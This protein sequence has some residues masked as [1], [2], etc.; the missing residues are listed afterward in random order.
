MNPKDG[1]SSSNPT[2]PQSSANFSRKPLPAANKSSSSKTRFAPILLKPSTKPPPTDEVIDVDEIGETIVNNDMHARKRHRIEPAV[3]RR[4]PPSNEALVEGLQAHFGYA[5]FRGFQQEVVRDVVC[6]KDVLV[7]MPTGGG[8][9]ICYQLPALLLPGIAIIISPL[10]ALMQDQ[11]DALRRRGIGAACFHSALPAPVRAQLITVLSSLT[12][13]TSSS[14]APSSSSSLSALP[15]IPHPLKL[16]YTTPETLTS[17]RFFK[18]LN[19]LRLSGQLSM[20][21]V[22]EA[23]C[24]SEWGHEFR[25]AYRKIGQIRDMLQGVPLVA[26]TATANATVK[27]DIVSQ[28]KLQNPGMYMA[29]FDRPEIYYSVAYKDHV[30]SLYAHLIKFLKQCG[31]RKRADNEPSASGIIYCQK[32]TSCDELASQLH[33]DGFQARAYHAGLSDSDRQQILDGFIKD[34]VSIVVATIAFGMGIDKHNVRFVVH[35]E[36][37]AN[38]ESFYQ[39]SGRAG[40]DKKCS[41]SLVYYSKDDSGVREF[42]ARQTIAKE[43]E[44]PM[45]KHAN[46]TCPLES[47]QKLKAVFEAFTCRRAAILEFFGEKRLSSAT[48]T[49]P[50]PK[51]TPPTSTPPSST[52]PAMSHIA[53]LRA[54]LCKATAVSSSPPPAIGGLGYGCCD[55]CNDTANAR[56]HFNAFA[57]PTRSFTGNRAKARADTKGLEMK[58]DWDED[59]FDEHD[60]HSDEDTSHAPQTHLTGF[61]SARDVLTQ[62]EATGPETVLRFVVDAKN[63]MQVQSVGAMHRSST[64]LSMIRGLPAVIDKVATNEIEK[65]RDSLPSSDDAMEKSC[66]VLRAVAA[67]EHTMCFLVSSHITQYN[68]TAQHVITNILSKLGGVAE[69]TKLAGIRVGGNG[70]GGNSAN[71]RGRQL[72][73]TEAVGSKKRTASPPKDIFELF[74]I[75]T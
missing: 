58:W 45:Q 13:P 2:R 35:M 15:P 55:V 28:L 34:T 1:L 43:L 5:S 53:S 40:R 16:L 19:D 18:I 59:G 10:I 49:P 62:A 17:D 74:G 72:T 60:R 14:D 33:T 67:L 73:L 44:A 66:V 46:R 75:K 6:G 37:P 68:N 20:V 9:S 48:S 24:I 26:T 21:A 30:P 12:L 8:K 25:P 27:K 63:V 57:H 31:A 32:R 71:G 65:V 29:S 41:Y 56:A 11:V 52:P 7:I 51:S 70:S 64:I 22:D 54:A 36:V 69:L 42:L 38:M 61:K 50:T 47:F 39:Q 23:H 3:P 4:P